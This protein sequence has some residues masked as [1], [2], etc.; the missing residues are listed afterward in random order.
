MVMKSMVN[1]NF[2]VHS[3]TGEFIGMDI[4][5]LKYYILIPVKSQSTKIL[6]I[7]S[8]NKI[9]LV[10]K[11]PKGF[12][13]LEEIKSIIEI[14]NLNDNTDLKDILKCCESIISQDNAQ[15]EQKNDK[16]IIEGT[17]KCFIDGYKIDRVLG[18][19]FYYVNT[20]AGQFLFWPDKGIVI[21]EHNQYTLSTLRNN[22][23]TIVG[24]TIPPICVTMLENFEFLT[25]NIVELQRLLK[26]RDNKTI[27]GE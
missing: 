4:P 12:I 9:G 8:L 6:F 19:T 26:E 10:N 15:K 18:L 3:F 14:F 11:C 17:I 13:G 25:T 20:E 24:I 7:P 22:F 27:K 2:I 1:N 21:Y 16:R 23:E 5:K